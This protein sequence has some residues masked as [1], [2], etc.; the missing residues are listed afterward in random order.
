MNE[1]PH[2]MGR[3]GYEGKK[4]QWLKEELALEVAREDVENAD[5]NPTITEESISS[6]TS[7]LNNRAF[8]W[9]KGHTP[10]S[11]AP[12]PKTKKVID[13]VVSFFCVLIISNVICKFIFLFPFCVYVKYYLTF[14]LCSSYE[15]R[16]TGM[17][18]RKKA[19]MFLQDLMMR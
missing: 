10:S 5:S 16:I 11:G 17:K 7:R 12:P 13:V 19:S 15:N 1:Y 18:R 9:V 8:R 4:E 3:A 14:K 2:Y 6:V